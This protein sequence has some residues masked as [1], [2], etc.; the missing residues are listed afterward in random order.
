MD[1]SGLF[2]AE[3]ERIAEIKWKEEWKKIEDDKSEADT[4]SELRYVV[5]DKRYLPYWQ[6]KWKRA[7]QRGRNRANQRAVIKAL[8]RG[9]LEYHF[10]KKFLKDVQQHGKKK[11]FGNLMPLAKRWLKVTIGFNGNLKNVQSKILCKNVPIVH[12]Q[13]EEHSC[14]FSSIASAFE[15]MGCKCAAQHIVA[16]KKNLIG[17]DANTQWMGLRNLLQQKKHV[18]EEMYFKVYTLQKDQ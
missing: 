15:Y 12:Q 18:R 17:K 11:K 16:N 2:G 13:G 9:W 10:T 14:L 4:M 3:K 8:D 7:N 6:G 5:D 1:D